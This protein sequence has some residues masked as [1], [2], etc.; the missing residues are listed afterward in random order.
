VPLGND[1][2]RQTCSLARTLEVVGERWT[3]LIVRDLFMG[4]QRFSDLVAHL[5]IPRAILS[6]RLDALVHEGIVERRPYSASRHDFHLTPAGRELWPSVYAL[7]QWGE[8]HRCA[9]G[10]AR[11]L[12]LHADCG[13]ELDEAGACPACGVTP[14]PDAVETRPGSGRDRPPRE[15]AVSVALRAPHRLLTPL[16]AARRPPTTAA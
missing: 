7:T 4:I 6:A 13:T 9:G 8:R 10:G 16:R 1:Y 3:L 2:D 12:W 11:R 15:D 14:A 5:D